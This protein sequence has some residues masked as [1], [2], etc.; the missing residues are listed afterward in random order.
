MTQNTPPVFQHGSAWVRADFH[1]HTRKDIKEFS[2]SGEDNWYVS[3]YV[4]GLKKAGV[5][6]GVIA[7]HNKF[8]FDEFRTLRKNARRDEILL[9]P[10]VELSVKDGSHGLHVL[11]V[12]Q[13]EWIC[14][15]ENKNYIQSFVD[16]T[17]AGQSNFEN[18]NGRSNHDLI[19]TIREL[20]KFERDYF[21]VYAHVEAKNGLWGGLSGGRIEELGRN[22]LF[23][24]RSLGFQKVE[25]RDTRD[26]VAAWLGDWYP[27]EVEGSD[28]KAIEQIG[29][30]KSCFLR[31]GAFTF[32]A[33][34]YALLDYSNRVSQEP[35]KH[36]GS[37]ISSVAFE[38]GVLDGKTIHFSSELN[39]LIGIRGSGKSSILEAVRYALDIPFGEKTL[40]RDYKE[41]LIAHTLGSGGKVTVQAVD[42]RGQ[43][44][45]IRRIYKEQPDV[46]IEDILQP[47]ISIRDTVIH[48]P[49]YFGQKDL[50]S[51]GEG[52]EK[53]LVE[54]LVG[55]KLRDIR[56][57]IDVQRRLVTDAVNRLKQLSMTEE[58][59]REYEGKKQ[60]AE[61]RLKFFKDHGVEEKLQKQLDFD[62]DSRKCAQVVS[63]AK[64]YLSALE[65][66][67]NRHEDDLRNQ[68]VYTSR[69]NEAFFK[70][71]FAIYEKLIGSFQKIKDFVSEGNAA[72]SELQGKA[73]EFEAT[74]EGL[75]E[76]FAGIERQLAAELKDTG[77]EAIRPAEFRE[78]R[79]TVEQAKQMLEALEKQEAQKK[80]YQ[81]DLLRQLSELNDRWHEEYKAIEAELEK[82]NRNHS[83]LQIKADYKGDKGTFLS[84]MKDMFRGSRLRENTFQTLVASYSDFGAIYKDF[85][86][87]KATM[88]SSTDTFAQY[89][90]ENLPALLTWQVH[91]R[92][93]IE[94]RGKALKHHSLG[95]RASA[96]IL[97]VLS[98]RENDVII[99]DQPEDDLDN[100]TIYEDVIKLIREIKPNTQFIFATHNANF[101]VLGDAEQVVSCAYADNA[102]STASGS[103]DC[104]ELQQ[105]IVNIMEGGEEAFNN[106]KRIY[107]TWK[108]R[109]S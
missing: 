77:V 96:L 1:L 73:K 26:K 44:Y 47:G 106:R 48:K 79:K 11:V 88:G 17:F 12:F 37:H 34:K 83:A 50:S 29:Q 64:Q 36:E 46:Y 9:L 98:Q 99:I 16:V 91:N 54:K 101:P 10:G 14:N 15:Q 102:I 103:I 90:N 80:E 92:F 85:D 51:S 42:Q 78:L 75:K 59:K 70:E 56:E 18:E 32:E 41:S 19:E 74:R 8:D 66:F 24:K 84:F 62:A 45:E 108:P 94:Y 28:C 31:L 40:D 49:I 6:V 35:K 104:P 23:R 100:Q 82:V 4:E 63:Y 30:G 71:F 89:F 55:E 87:A 76:E 109:N 68:T 22:D 107:E 86:N 61:F 81:D 95:Q 3:S 25:T 105:K 43:R 57:R 67:V 21:L 60:D 5:R 2:Y 13:E 72:L 52:F 97:F 7:N 27:A 20:D 58:K 69:Q 65:E 93:I 33:V 39:A 53:D 38:G